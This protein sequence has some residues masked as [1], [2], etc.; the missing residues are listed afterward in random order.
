M[1]AASR[2]PRC[3]RWRPLARQ[4]TE[5]DRQLQATVTVAASFSALFH[6]LFSWRRCTAGQARFPTLHSHTAG[7]GHHSHQ[8]RRS[9]PVASARVSGTRFKESRFTSGHVEH[10]ML[11]PVCAEA[12]LGPFSQ[13]SQ[14]TLFGEFGIFPSPLIQKA[15]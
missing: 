1:R 11:A 10:Q 14:E 6:T 12:S 5:Q 3:P 4:L 9:A 15:V 8:R 13:S 2:S 7:P